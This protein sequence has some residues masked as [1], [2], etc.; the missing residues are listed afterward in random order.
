MK[1]RLYYVKDNAILKVKLVTMTELNDP[2]ISIGKNAYEK[3]Q[4][5]YIGKV[6]SLD[7]DKRNCTIKPDFG[8]E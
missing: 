8:K 2:K 5:S 1:E 4:K 3:E 6:V 7:V